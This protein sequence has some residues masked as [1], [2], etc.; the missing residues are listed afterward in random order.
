MRVMLEILTVPDPVLRKKAKEVTK[1]DAQAK[2]II[3]EMLETL[4]NNPRGGIGLAAPQVGHSLRIILVKDGRDEGSATFVLVNPEII[5]TSKEKESAYEGCLS[6]PNL[7]AQVERHLRL[8]VRAQNKNGKKVSIKASN[9][10]AR[11]LE[12]EIDH[13]DG[14]L[15]TDK[16]I[17]P[18][19]TQSQ[20]DRLI[21]QSTT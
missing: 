14:I 15:I 6:I 16:M 7:Y 8:V 21:D 10:L 9:L 1:I 18:P 5:K 19:L 4:Q 13:L 2:K 11:V 12:H 3:E 17:G 20:Y